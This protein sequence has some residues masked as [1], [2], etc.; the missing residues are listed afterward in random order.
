MTEDTIRIAALNAATYALEA[1]RHSPNRAT[2]AAT[3]A[4]Q[5]PI[6]HSEAPAPPVHAVADTL[7]AVAQQIESYLRSTGRSL[8]FKV[9]GETG[10]TIVTVRDSQTGEI[11]RQIPGEETLRLARSLGNQPNVL[12]DLLA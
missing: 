9:D 8:E 2:T 1:E 11:V 4:P 5:S 10:R 12:I 3:Q 7:A 6:Q